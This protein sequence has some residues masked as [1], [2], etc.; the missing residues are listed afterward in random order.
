MCHDMHDCPV[1][2]GDR[3]AASHLDG[4]VQWATTHN[5]LLIVTF[6]EDSGSDNNRIVTFVAGAGIRAAAIPNESITTACYEPSNTGTS[7][8]PRRG[9]HRRAAAGPALLTA[10]RPQLVRVGELLWA[11]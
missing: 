6:D 1:S 4:Y 11:S 7:C 5:S 10:G 2:S 3:W 8:A 9:V